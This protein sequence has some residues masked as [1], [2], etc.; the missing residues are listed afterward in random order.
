MTNSVRVRFA[1]SPTG[2][3]H[4]GNIRTAMFNWLFARHTGGRFILRIEDTD[5]ARKV[6]GAVEAIFEGLRWLGLDWEEG[7]E[8]DGDY[9]PS[10]QS[11]GLKVSPDR[12]KH[13]V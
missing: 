4:V 3:P 10:F 9:G 8:A 6:E 11:Q 7:P 5:I 12:A 1:P 2:F 13:A